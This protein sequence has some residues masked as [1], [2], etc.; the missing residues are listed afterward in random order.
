M[1]SEY[2]CLVGSMIKFNFIFQFENFNKEHD[3]Y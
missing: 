2:Q 3:F 1:L